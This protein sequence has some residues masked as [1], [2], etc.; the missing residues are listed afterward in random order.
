MIF[1]EIHEGFQKISG[2]IKM[3]MPTCLSNEKIQITKK[4]MKINE[5]IFNYTSKIIILE[6]NA[7]TVCQIFMFVHWP[8]FDDL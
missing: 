8:L 4:S 7:L 5:A 1:L 2:L 6:I 3:Y